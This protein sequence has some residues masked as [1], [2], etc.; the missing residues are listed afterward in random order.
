MAEPKVD[1]GSLF[2]L[3]QS[4]FFVPLARL[5]AATAKLLLNGRMT[6]EERLRAI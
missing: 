3:L 4:Y 1:W 6:F 2:V 5:L